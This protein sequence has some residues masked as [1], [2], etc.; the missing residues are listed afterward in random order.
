LL[1]KGAQIAYA[2][3]PRPWLRPRLD[4]DLLIRPSDR[5]G[6]DDVLRALGYR[7]G[8]DFSGDLVTHQ[9]QY[10][11]PDQYGLTHIIDLHWKVANPYVFADVLQFDELEADGV[12]MPILGRGARGLSDRHALLV[13]CIHRVAHHDN[14]DRLIWFYDIQLLATAMSAE[15]REEVADVARAKHLGAVCASGIT[16]ALDRFRTEIP[17]GWVDRLRTNGRDAETTAAFLQDRRTKMHVLLS[18]FRVLRGW[19]PKLRLIQQHLFPPAA[20]IRRAYAVSHRSF[21][22]LAYAYRIVRGVGKWVRRH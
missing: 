22:P 13:A 9:F 19:R 10:E 7:P 6:A 11:R 8:T 1:I 3:Y 20:Y 5:C 14:S 18:D 15:R 17:R 16:L 4:T 2:H 12:P 21:L